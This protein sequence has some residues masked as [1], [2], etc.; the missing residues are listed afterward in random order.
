MSWGFPRVPL[1]LQSLGGFARPISRSG[2][3]EIGMTSKVQVGPTNREGRPP[4]RPGIQLFLRS[5]LS[6]RQRGQVPVQRLANPR[7]SCGLKQGQQQRDST[8]STG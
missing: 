6:F 2:K 7:G 4:E 1:G 8:M 5:C 3:N